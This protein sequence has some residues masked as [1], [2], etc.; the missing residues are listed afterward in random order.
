MLSDAET[1][2]AETQTWLAFAVSCDYLDRE[3]GKKLFR[4]YEEIIKMIVAMI[5]HPEK[6]LL[7][8]PKELMSL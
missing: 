3:V 8:S 6:W 4:A 5:N 1:E 7:K 2:A